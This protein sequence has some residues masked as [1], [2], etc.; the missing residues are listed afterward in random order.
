MR[1]IAF[2]PGAAQFTVVYSTG[3]YHDAGRSADRQPRGRFHRRPRR[4]EP[5]D[6]R[7]QARTSRWTWAWPGSP[8]PRVGTTLRVHGIHDGT[9]S[10]HG[11]LVENSSPGVVVY[12]ISH[13]GWWAHNYIWRQPGWEKILAAMQPD[14]T[15]IF[16]TKPESG[17]S[18]PPSDTRKN[19]EYEMLTDRVL[20]A[21]PKTQLLFFKCWDP[22][23][24]SVRPDA[25]TWKDR[26]AWFESR[27]IRVPRPATG[28]RQPAR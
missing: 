9:L 23:T 16:L 28:A 3:T 22:A 15:I 17:G 24:G 8:C 25:Q 7:G 20:G 14:L 19:P 26:T 2:P 4:P 1:P 10:L 18:S 6:P 13:G 27:R 12:N 5:H 21:V 11:V